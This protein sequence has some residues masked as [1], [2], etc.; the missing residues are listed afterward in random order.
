MNVRYDRVNKVL[1]TDISDKE[2]VDINKRLGLAV[3]L[4]KDYFT[5]KPPAFRPDIKTE[6]DVIEEI[7]R[8]YGYQKIR[9]TIPKAVISGGNSGWKHTYAL[10]IK[11]I[12]RRAGFNEAINYS[13]MAGNRP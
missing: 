9:T 7:A 10:R 4:H 11:D 5:V 13:F 12:V 3:D 2:M 1:G 8:V 6:S